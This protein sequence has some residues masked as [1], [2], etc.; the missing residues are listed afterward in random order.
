VINTTVERIRGAVQLLCTGDV[1]LENVTVFEA[2]DFSFDVSATSGS[3]ILMKGCRGDVAYS[4]AFNLTRGDLPKKA[5]YEITILS[6]PEGSG[7]TPRSSLGKICGD[8]CRFILRDG[9][10]RPLPEKVNFLVCGGDK[11]LVD[12]VIERHTGAKLI[13]K[14]NVRNCTIKSVG[15][16]EDQG[17][18]HK[19]VVIP[20]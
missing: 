12:S 6:P 11:E 20:K 1:T 9:T 15:P 17:A 10:T 3:K 18:G 4:P 2:G 14:K 13:L 19:I 5:N 8:Q 7:S 16:V